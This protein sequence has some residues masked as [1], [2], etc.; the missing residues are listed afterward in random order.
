MPD[1]RTPDRLPALAVVCALAL[2][3][4][5]MAGAGIAP[6][7]G[8]GQELLGDVR[9]PGQRAFIASHRGG[10][11]TAPE[12]TIPAIRHALKSGFDYV[13]IDLVLTRDGHAVLMHD[14]TVDRTTDGTGAVADLTLAEIRRLDAGA[15][16]DPAYAGTPVPTAREALAEIAAHGGRAILDL[17]GPWTDAAAADL[18]AEIERLELVE[19]VAVASFD[20]RTLTQ[21]AAHSEVIARLATVKKLPPDAVRALQGAGVRGVI[22]DRRE[23]SAHPDTVQE[24]HDADLRVVAY[25]LNTDRQWSTATELGVD[26]IV[27]DDPGL[28]RTWQSAP[29]AGALD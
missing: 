4:L 19:A 15:G 9:A 18:V 10:A 17:K 3:T 24:L 14:A 27:T 28:L 7:A 2:A 25:T 13:E 26:G 6:A 20:A 29:A 11:E 1:V 16:Y 5:L 21:I 8:S 22:V 12:N 23:L